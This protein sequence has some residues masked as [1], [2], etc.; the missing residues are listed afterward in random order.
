MDWIHVAL[1]RDQ[2]L[3][4]VNMIMKFVS[5]KGREFLGQLSDYKL[6]SSGVSQSVCQLVNKIEGNIYLMLLCN[7]IPAI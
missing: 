2:W 1:D 6:I 7:V 5:T 4:L 3:A